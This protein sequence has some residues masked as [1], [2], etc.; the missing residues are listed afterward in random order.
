[1]G[2]QWAPKCHYVNVL[3]NGAFRGIYL[4]IEPVKRN[5][6]CRLDVAEDGYITLRIRTIWGNGSKHEINLVTGTNKDNVYELTLRH[7][8]NGDLQG[9]YADALVAF[10]LNSLYKNHGD[11]VK[12]RLN[13]QS[14]SGKKSLDV[15]L[16]M[17]SAK[18]KVMEE[19]LPMCSR[20][21]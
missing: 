6:K 16:K 13:W 8:A 17:H 10:D 3:F 9:R 14:F 7:N 5:P 18:T 11:K 2:L 4:L 15:S 12:L 20:I 19:R 21:D 1:M